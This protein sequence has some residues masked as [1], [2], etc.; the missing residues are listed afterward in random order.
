MKPYIFLTQG[1][2]SPPASHIFKIFF[3]VKIIS[4]FQEALQPVKVQGVFSTA[5]GAEDNA[6][7]RCDSDRHPNVKEPHGVK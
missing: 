3:L 2:D 5:L 7:R 1:F 4:F 6:C